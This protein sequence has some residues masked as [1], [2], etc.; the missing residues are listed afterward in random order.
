MTRAEIAKNYFESGFA[1]S[2]AVAMA[3]QKDVGVDLE[4][5]QKLSLPFGG[6]LG[7]LR[8]TCGAVS[9]MAI[10]YGL[11]MEAK[12]SPEH[13]M[14]VYEG[15]RELCARFERVHGSLVCSELLAMGKKPCSEI[16]YSATEILENYLKE[17]G[18]L[19]D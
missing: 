8:L 9:G 7:R 10:V 17:K 3:F 14:S 12:N 19:N 13:K 6:G 4:T 1:C 5:L 16:V 18:Y 11:F 2:Q 15:T